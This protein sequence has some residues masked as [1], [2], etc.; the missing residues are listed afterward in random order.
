M[1]RSLETEQREGAG[2]GGRKRAKDYGGERATAAEGGG[3]CGKWTG[4]GALRGSDCGRA[5]NARTRLSL[6]CGAFFVL[7]SFLCAVEPLPGGLLA[8]Q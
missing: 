6:C 8:A 2:H 3:V 4:H 5:H 7:W 1:R